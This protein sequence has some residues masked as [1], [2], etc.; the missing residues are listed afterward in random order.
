MDDNKKYFTQGELADR[1]KI[2]DRSLERRRYE[3]RPPAYVKIGSSVRY[4]LKEIERCER[5]WSVGEFG[6]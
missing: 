1:W 2:S 3:D 4:E 6:L 5:V